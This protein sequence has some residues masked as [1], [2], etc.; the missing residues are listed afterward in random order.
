M[1][2]YFAALLIALIVVKLSDLASESIMHKTVLEKPGYIV[3]GVEKESMAPVAQEEKAEPISALMA[4]ASIENGKKIAQRCVQC[5]G[6]DKG[7]PH[8]LGPNLW[9]VV[10]SKLASKDGYSYSEGMKAKKREWSIE[11]LNLYLYNPK[12]FVPGT[13]MVFVGMKN[14]QERADLISFL[15][16]LK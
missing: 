15:S 2:K 12:S 4:S 3:A 11:N 9:A 13:K 1:N 8:K 6:L 7:D 14:T 5:H 10:N 16:S